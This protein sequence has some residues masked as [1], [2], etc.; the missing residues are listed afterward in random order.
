MLREIPSI[1]MISFFIPWSSGKQTR[2][3]SDGGVE[4]VEDELRRDADREH[5]QCDGND[6]ELFASQ[7]IGE[8]A[9]TLGQGTAEERLHG[10]RKRNRRDEQTNYCDRSKRSGDGKGTF[11]NKKFADE[12]V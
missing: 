8:R 2:H 10:A 7:K 11:E 9:A 1:G 6:D 3:L 4:D 5:E 12:S